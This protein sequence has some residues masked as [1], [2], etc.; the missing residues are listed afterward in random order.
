VA[1]HTEQPQGEKA[2]VAGSPK[3]NQQAGADASKSKAGAT[4]SVMA[5]QSKQDGNRQDK[6]KQDP[7]KP[8][9]PQLVAANAKNKS[10][11]ASKH[12]NGAKPPAKAK[13]AQTAAKNKDQHPKK[14]SG[15][16]EKPEHEKQS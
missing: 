4:S 5:G 8:A 13:A 7:G 2:Q 15:K 14:P 1:K 6:A 10:T 9:N 16:D 11:D 3:V 12:P